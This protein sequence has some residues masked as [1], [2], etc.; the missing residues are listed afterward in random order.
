MKDHEL[1][2]G[3]DTR[4]SQEVLAGISDAFLDLR[5]SICENRIRHSGQIGE[6]GKSLTKRKADR[7]KALLD[8]FIDLQCEI[9][10]VLY[11]ELAK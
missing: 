8:N 6:A 4:I 11:D 9:Y 2:S 7:L 3:F 5:N 1:D 10:C